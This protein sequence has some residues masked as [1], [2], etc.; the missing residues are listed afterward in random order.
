MLSRLASVVART[1]EQLNTYQFGDY[2]R[3]IQQFFWNDVCDWYIELCKG[4]LLGTDAD[5][6]TLAQRNLVFVLDTS[7]RLMHPVMPFVT[8]AIWD[9]LP[10]SGLGAHDERCL[11]YTS[12][13]PRD[14]G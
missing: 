6:R 1:T 2:A 9:K 10:T 8:E 14:R 7:L 3:D 13:S 5:E 12:P 4:R 11:L